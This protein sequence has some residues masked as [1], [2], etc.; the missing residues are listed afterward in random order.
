MKNFCITFFVFFIIIAT[1]IFAASFGGAESGV[2]LSSHEAAEFLRIHVRANSNSG[3]DQSVKYKVK[4]AVVEFITPIAA[5]SATKAEAVAAINDNLAAIEEVCDGVL[6]ENG[7]Y[8]G[9]NAE[10]R[11]ESF[12]T[13]VYGDLTLESGEYDALIIELGS[14]SGDNW[15]CVLYPPLCFT[16][17]SQDVTYRSL[18]YDIISGFFA[19]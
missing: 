19:K 1:V 14:G 17:A 12:P 13:R 8:Y 11:S 5:T 3:D 18:I 7:Y 6:R 4:D 9:A 2:S 16:S 15:W 10:V